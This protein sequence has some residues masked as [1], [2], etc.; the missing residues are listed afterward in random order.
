MSKNNSLF[1]ENSLMYENSL[2]ED[3]KKNNGI[4]Y[5]DIE[6]AN[7]IIDFLDIPKEAS[8]IDPW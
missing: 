8:I 5:T 4:F 7:A 2:D 1:S 6:L 3:F